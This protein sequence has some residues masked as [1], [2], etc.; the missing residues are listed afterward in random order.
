MRLG[1]FGGSFNPIHLAHLRCAEEAREMLRLDRVL[2]VPSASPPHKS[3][4]NLVSAA[5]RMSMVRRAI[6]GHPCFRASAIEIERPGRSYSV[7]TLRLLRAK[8]PGSTRLVFILGLDAFREIETWK[9]YRALFGLADLAIVSRPHVPRGDLES[10][11]PVAAKGEFCYS[12]SHK[13]LAHQSG[14]RIF[15]LN[16][17][18]LD[19]SA[20][21]IR[22]RLA[23]QKSIRYLVPAA[24]ERYITRNGL[25]VR[26]RTAS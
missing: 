25:Y 16:V 6:A 17:T 3:N 23:R 20:S 13:V 19:I 24:V 14:N 7:D 15:F 10:L 22:L 9:E 4:R 1:V 12:R 26:G 5:H 8:L 21:A 18:G 11:L 2:F